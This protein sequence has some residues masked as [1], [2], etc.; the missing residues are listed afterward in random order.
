MAFSRTQ[1]WRRAIP[2]LSLLMVMAGHASGETYKWVDEK[3]VTQYGD[4]LPPEYS[5]KANTKLNKRGVETKKTERA[6]T[7]AEI[8]ARDDEAERLKQEATKA[9]EQKRLD[10]IMLATYANESEIDLVRD[11]SLEPFD[12]K[13]LV[14]RERI[15]YLQPL[16]ADL[17]KVMVPYQD[18]TPSGQKKTPP[19]RLT[20]DIAAKKKE[21]G[22][23]ERSIKN[24]EIDKAALVTK[25]SRDK[26]R[27]REIAAAGGAGKRLGNSTEKDKIPTWVEVN[28]E[29]AQSCLKNWQDTLGGEAY[30][31]F[32]EIKRDGQLAGLVLE[33][34]VHK[35][36]GEFA[37]VKATCPMRA[38]GSF[39]QDGIRA[40]RSLYVTGKG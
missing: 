16:L 17:S 8:K 14:A 33:T 28:S 31:V 27:F 37:N 9:K 39:D 5:Q 20:K 25:Y 2:L 22:E 10:E 30:A 11:R 32:A 15:K 34:R 24:L 35:K 18:T 6:M 19:A 12:G 40:K 7:P 4:R 38:D 29:V 21:I 36:T 3:G 1:I 23:L 13:T 26:Q